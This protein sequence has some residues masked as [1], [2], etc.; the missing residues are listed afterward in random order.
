MV[1]H[2]CPAGIGIGISGALHLVEDADR[3]ITR[4]GFSAGPF[5]DCGEGNLT[6]LWR[7]LP[8]KPDQWVF[9]HFHALH[10][11][12][13]DHTRFV[14]VGSTDDTDGVPGVRPVIYDTRSRTLVMDPANCL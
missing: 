9:G 10:D 5:H 1:S 14:C 6:R 13:I 8:H 2:S 11:R 4:P 3:F 7:Q 12:T